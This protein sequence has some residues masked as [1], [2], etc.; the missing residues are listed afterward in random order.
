MDDRTD[1]LAG[2]LERAHKVHAVVAERSGGVDPDWALFYAWWLLNWSDFPDV[3]GRTP[4]LAELT[5]ELTALD[6]AYRAGPQELPWP[7]A[8]ARTLVGAR[9]RR[10][11]LPVVRGGRVMPGVDLDDSAALLD[12]M[13]GEGR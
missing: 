7:T 10:V 2:I 13:D 12:V 8:Y 4:S 1:R 5:V 9:D 11:D 6:A 3:L